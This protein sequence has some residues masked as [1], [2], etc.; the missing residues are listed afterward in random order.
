MVFATLDSFMNPDPLQKISYIKKLIRSG[1]GQH[2]D[3]KFEISDAK[4]IARTFSA[5]ANT[6]GGT[7]LIGVKDNGKISG[8][9]SD[10]EEFMVE[11]AA[12]IF[13]KPE[14]PYHVKRWSVEGK[15][16]LEVEIP[17]SLARPHVARDDQGMWTAYVRVKDENIKANKVLVSVW[18]NQRRK[19]SAFI[20]Y[21]KEEKALMDYLS[22][23]GE[24]SFHKF[25]K[26]ARIGP[27]HAENILVNLILMDAIEI[28]I[29]EQGFSYSRKPSARD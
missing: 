12:H 6:S 4:K 24:I 29:T 13:C 22:D 14:V 11:S 3:F 21:Q 26:I 8:V 7:L 19:K 10:E 28:N 17:M 27:V 15:Q 16:V 2:L 20:S 18:K 23:H 25:L 5:F 1:E 9:Q